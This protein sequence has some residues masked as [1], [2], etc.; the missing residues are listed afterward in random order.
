MTDQLDIGQSGPEE[1]PSQTVERKKPGP[2]PKAAAAAG[3]APKRKE[4]GAGKVAASRISY[5]DRN[6]IA[7]TGRDPNFHYRVVNVDNEKY[8][9]RIDKMQS[10]GYTIVNSGE[11][12]GDDL[13]VSSSQL[14]SSVGTH[15]GHGTKGVLMKIPLEYYNQDQADKQTEVDHTELGMVADELKNSGDVYGE[16]LKLSDSQGTRLET[17]V[18][19]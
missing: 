3:K 17:T 9:G 13:G 1:T 11:E 18:R 14:G 10:I 7:A 15:V 16:G 4:I 6:K 19:K 2:K 12:L 8:A 5:K